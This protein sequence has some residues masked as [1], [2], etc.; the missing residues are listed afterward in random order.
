M[1][2]HAGCLAPVPAVSDQLQLT[3]GDNRIAGEAAIFQWV[4]WLKDQPILWESN[5]DGDAEGAS[6][7]YAETDTADAVGSGRSAAAELAE[8]EAIPEA[9][10]RRQGQQRF[11]SLGSPEVGS[12]SASDASNLPIWCPLESGMHIMDNVKYKI[13]NCLCRLVV[14]TTKP[15]FSKWQKP[16]SRRRR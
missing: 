15:R 11:G 9:T 2:L 14:T 6:C 3:R 13:T 10:G 7:T 16:S 1:L 5:S 4:E 12:A 8:L